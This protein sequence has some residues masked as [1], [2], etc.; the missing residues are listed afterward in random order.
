[1]SS[2][3]ATQSPV[4]EHRV[5]SLYSSTVTFSSESGAT[6]IF[7]RQRDSHILLN[8]T[9]Y[10]DAAARP[11]FDVANFQQ[12]YPIAHGK[13]PIPHTSILIT[14][15]VFR[16]IKLNFNLFGVSPLTEHGLSATYTNDDYKSLHLL[17]TD[18][19]LY[20]TASN[21]MA[22]TSGDSLSRSLAPQQRTTSSDT[23]STPDSPCT[24]RPYLA[25]KGMAQQL[26][27]PHREDPQPKP[28]S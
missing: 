25:R 3:I 22:T 7:M 15:F 11:G 19:K 27:C 4:P 2:T 23:S 8:Y 24:L 10:S 9:T 28:T 1:V 12:I 21:K 17:L 14:A 5:F 13:L 6:D 26:P 16:D 20:Y 18:L